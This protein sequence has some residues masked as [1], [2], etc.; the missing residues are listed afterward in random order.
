MAQPR[1]PRD[2]RTI[3]AALPLIEQDLADVI[4]FGMLFLANPDLPA[5][6]AGSGPFDTPD[7]ATFYGG[8]RG[9]TDYPALTEETAR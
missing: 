2:G 9:H 5:R 1:S 3:A 7:R 8:G 4:S 6:L